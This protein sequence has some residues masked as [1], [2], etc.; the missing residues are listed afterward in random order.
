[1]VLAHIVKD[2]AQSVG[3]VVSNALVALSS[4]NIFL[5]AQKSHMIIKNHVKSVSRGRSEFAEL[6]VSK[7]LFSSIYTDNILFNLCGL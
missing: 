3:E 7:Q 5:W 2:N 1:M 6:Q 4:Q